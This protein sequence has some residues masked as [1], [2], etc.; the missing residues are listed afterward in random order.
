MN[1]LF[2]V[3][4]AEIL[5]QFIDPFGVN[6]GFGGTSFTTLRL[7]QELARCPD[8]ATGNLKI[9]LGAEHSNVQSYQGIPVADLTEENSK[10]WD[11]AILTGGSL[12][13][14]YRGVLRLKAT[15]LLAW[16]RHPYD[17]DKIHKARKLKAELVSVG[18][19]QFLSNV[20]IG[21]WHHHIDNLF[22]AERIRNAASPQPEPES[23]EAIQTW[24]VG[25]MGALVPSKGLHE[26]AE[27]WP[28]ICGLLRSQGKE[29][30][31]DVI[32][33]AGLYAFKEGHPRLP[34]SESYGNTL[35]RLF[36][37]ELNRSVK[38]HGTLGVERY[39]IIRHCDVAVVNPSGQ[40]EAFPATILEWLAL[41]IP[42][43]SS[44]RYGCADAMQ[45]L[46]TTSIRKLDEIPGKI[47]TLASLN[48]EKLEDLKQH[49]SRI[50]DLFSSQQALI[51]NQWRLL[52]Q[53]PMH[54]ETINEYLAGHIYGLLARQWLTMQVQ[55]LKNKL[56]RWA[57]PLNRTTASR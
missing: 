42:V 53:Q 17:W 45:H 50:A 11:V 16:I 47:Q 2:I 49:C 12:E 22:C 21:G 1:V 44:Q 32:G 41:G 6:P 33:G 7:A 51:V 14:L 39:Q 26:L 46:H 56:R 54:A 37:A 55:R 15:R 9:W 38:F 10:S 40:G 13:R 19:A 4:Q 3:E 27:Q 31:L 29:P 20:V 5:E 36:G 18:K 28:S 8:A 43:I 52:L 57:R 34:C 24:R 48:P 23:S 25:F 35:E 30:L